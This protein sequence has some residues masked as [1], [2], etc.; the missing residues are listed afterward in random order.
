MSVRRE[1]GGVRW[2]PHG[3]VHVD[4][5]G[6]R[7]RNRVADG[8]KSGAPGRNQLN[9]LDLLRKGFSPVGSGSFLS[10]NLCLS[11]LLTESM[12]EKIRK[13]QAVESF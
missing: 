9:C 13:Q 8:K 6:G 1:F 12:L 2:S 11:A 3:M 7:S 10:Q 5:S 4:P